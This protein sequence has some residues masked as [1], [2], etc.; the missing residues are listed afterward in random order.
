[1]RPG[2]WF[3][4]NHNRN[5]T[6]NRNPNGPEAGKQEEKR[7]SNIEQGMWKPTFLYVALAGEL[8]VFQEFVVAGSGKA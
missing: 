2:G 1:M 7:I 3:D 4:Y 8:V 6:L 5:H